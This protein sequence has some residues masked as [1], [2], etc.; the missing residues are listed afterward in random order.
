MELDIL[1]L[2]TTWNDAANSIN[3]NFSKIQMAIASLGTGGGGSSTLADLTDVLL[4]SLNNGDLLS[5]NGSAWIN[6]KQSA[7]VPNLTEY[8]TKGY[9]SNALVPYATKDNVTSALGGYLPLSGGTISGLLTINR[10]PSVI[11]FNAGDKTYGYLGVN[12]LG[13]VFYT[14]DSTGYDIIHSGNIGKIY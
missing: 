3:T 11:R 1:K 4:G 6:I 10:S 14:A 2:H 12:A 13:P 5:W 8:A 7:I 9:V